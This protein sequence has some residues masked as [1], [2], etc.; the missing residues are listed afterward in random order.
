MPDLNRVGHANT[1]HTYMDPSLAQNPEAAQGAQHAKLP[2]FNQIAHVSSNAFMLADEIEKRQGLISRRE[3]DRALRHIFTQFGENAAPSIDDIPKASMKAMVLMATNLSISTFSDTAQAKLKA[4]KIMTDTQAYL[5][6]QKVKK[7]QDQ[8][9]A[10]ADQ[11]A[12]ARKAGIFTAVFD[13]IISA[14]EAIYGI[15]KLVEGI[16]S[17]IVTFGADAEAYLEIAGGATYLAAGAAGLVKAAAETCALAGIGNKAI[18]DKVAEIAGYVQLGCEIAGMCVD[19]FGAGL[20]FKAARAGAKAAEEGVKIAADV[21]IKTGT[22]LAEATAGAS[23][24][25]GAEGM[26]ELEKIAA[27]EAVE[28][29]SKE[30]AEQVA[31]DVGSSIVQKISSQAAEVA[32]E[33]GTEEGAKIGKKILVKLTRRMFKRVS[34][35]FGKEAIKE[36]TKK[37]VQEAIEETAKQAAKEGGEITEDTVKDI[38]KLVGKK[39]SN[40]LLRGAVKISTNLAFDLARGAVQGGQQITKG[41][42]AE[43]RAVTE[44]AIQELIVEQEFLEFTSDWYDKTKQDETKSAKDLISKSGTALQGATDVITQTGSIQARI[45]G[46]IAG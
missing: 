18:E 2:T 6:D 45:A 4:Q 39:V 29:V 5:N 43:I 35:E 31:S 32:S 9:K 13:W 37:A 8:M 22:D 36:M 10:Q 12:K 44:K 16:A 17:A 42:I 1:H 30:I 34:K 40:R 33:E 38:G 46:S 28:Q 26:V 41:T 24:D 27:K 11:Q 25:A 21:I 3:A 14:A 7:Y 15:F 23:I 20:A 19:V